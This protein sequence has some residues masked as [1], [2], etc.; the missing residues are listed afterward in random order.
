M[1]CINKAFSAGIEPWVLSAND[2]CAALSFASR[3]R[4]VSRADPRTSHFLAIDRVFVRDAQTLSQLVDD[5]SFFLAL[6]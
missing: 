4:F 6:S 3:R 5:K 2:I 1:S